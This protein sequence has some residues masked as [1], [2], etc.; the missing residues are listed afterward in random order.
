MNS[1]YIIR[2]DTQCYFSKVLISKTVIQDPLGSFLGISLTPLA[3]LSHQNSIFTK[4]VTSVNWVNFNIPYM[5][6]II[7]DMNTPE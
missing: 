6:P 3:W 4:A 7:F 1:R 5:L 2:N